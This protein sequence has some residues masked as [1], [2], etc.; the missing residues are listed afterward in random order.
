MS[1][2]GFDMTKPHDGL[3]AGTTTTVPEAGRLLGLSRNAAYAA[4]ASGELP[5]LRFGKR[6]VVPT[7]PLKRM[8]GLG[9]D[10]NAENPA[11]AKAVE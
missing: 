8:L 5:T 3:L 9:T 4:A 6:I 2:K 11:G 1:T 10:E 7:M